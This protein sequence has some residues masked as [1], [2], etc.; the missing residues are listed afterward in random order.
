MC[1]CAKSGEIHIITL[2]NVTYLSH[3][4]QQIKPIQFLHA[5]QRTS[6]LFG[7]TKHI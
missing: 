5:E 6:V 3:S 7:A 4:C 1:S 2:H